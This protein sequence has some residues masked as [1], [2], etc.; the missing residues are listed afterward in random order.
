M[1]IDIYEIIQA[2]VAS[3]LENGIIPWRRCYH[4]R[5][6]EACISHQT[7]QEYSLLNQFMLDAPGEYWTF[8]QAQSE[9]YRIKKGAKAQ[10]VVFWKVLKGEEAPATDEEGVERLKEVRAKAIP[11]LKYYSVFHES[12]VD[13]LPTKPANMDETKNAE[14]VLTA[15]QI[16]ERYLTSNPNIKMTESE[17]RKPC[18]VP[19]EDTI[20]IPHRCQFDSAGDYYHTIFHEMTHSTAKR[21]GRELS[22]RAML[23]KY[24]KEELVAD[25]GAAYLC[26]AAGISEEELTDN[27]ASYCAGWLEPLKKNIKWLVWAA[28]RAE[29]A[30]KYILGEEA[31]KE[32]GEE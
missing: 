10:K 26:G 3:Q 13:G 31:E 1:S 18:F 5:G 23:E 28:S 21:M 20:Y 25:I 32:T 4:L 14:H 19:S 27:T 6:G 9:G 22:S 29:V 12:D 2:R 8:K 7:K 24:S 16:I 15:D 11:F 30:V 17:W